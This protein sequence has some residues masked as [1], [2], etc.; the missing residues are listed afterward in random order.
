MPEITDPTTVHLGRATAGQLRRAGFH[1]SPTT[2]ANDAT[3]GFEVLCHHGDET[4]VAEHAK[5]NGRGDAFP[6]KGKPA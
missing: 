2:T 3:S 6:P 4:S 1:V 5:A